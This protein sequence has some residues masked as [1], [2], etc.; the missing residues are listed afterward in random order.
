MKLDKTLDETGSFDHAFPHLFF[1][2]QHLLFQYFPQTSSYSGRSAG[3]HPGEVPIDAGGLF[4]QPAYGLPKE[5]EKRK[6]DMVLTVQKS[7]FTSQNF[8]L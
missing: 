5:N 2:L 1:A 3:Q 4:C 8:F 7:K 6:T